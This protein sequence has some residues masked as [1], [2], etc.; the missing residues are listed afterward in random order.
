M[1]PTTHATKPRPSGGYNCPYLRSTARHSLPTRQLWAASVAP[2]RNKLVQVMPP[3]LSHSRAAAGLQGASSAR[4]IALAAE[5]ESAS[6][7]PITR[8]AKTAVFILNRPSVIL[9]RRSG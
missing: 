7:G 5:P 2:Q 1:P 8:H 9:G 4:S 3:E 6:N